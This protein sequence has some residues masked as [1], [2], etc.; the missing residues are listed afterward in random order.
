M[1]TK[2]EPVA[3]PC[4]SSSTISDRAQQD[5]VWHRRCAVEEAAEERWLNSQLH[6]SR[7]RAA[8]L[9]DYLLKDRLPDWDRVQKPMRQPCRSVR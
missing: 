4:R 8:E 3:R 1:A 5:E 6:S 2:S 7:E 9:G